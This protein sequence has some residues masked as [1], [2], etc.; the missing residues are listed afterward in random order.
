M[1]YSLI[2][3][4]CATFLWF[5]S[6]S[7]LSRQF[8]SHWKKGF[9]IL[10]RLLWE[11]W[12]FSARL[13]RALCQ[14]RGR[15]RWMLHLPKCCSRP[16]KQMKLIHCSWNQTI[17]FIH[18]LPLLHNLS[19]VPIANCICNTPHMA[20][21]QGDCEGQEFVAYLKW[22]PVNWDVLTVWGSC[23]TNPSHNSDIAAIEGTPGKRGLLYCHSKIFHLFFFTHVSL[24]LLNARYASSTGKKLNGRK[25]LLYF[26]T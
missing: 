16:R 1:L 20:L 7:I 5:T 17:C 15:L 4:L 9:R 25:T 19:L 2:P 11:A 18:R 26:V 8:F 12:Y 24:S 23:A 10:G 13:H 21:L 22:T 3:N 14:S 6:T